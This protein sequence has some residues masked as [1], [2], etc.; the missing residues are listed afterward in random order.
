MSN[1]WS[2]LLFCIC[3][4]QHEL[5]TQK[6]ALLFGSFNILDGFSFLFL[7]VG[8]WFS[9][10]IPFFLSVVCVLLSISKRQI[11]RLN[12]TNKQINKRNVRK[13]KQN[14]LL[15]NKREISSSHF[16]A[17]IFVAN[18]SVAHNECNEFDTFFVVVIRTEREKKIER[19]SECVSV[20]FYHQMILWWMSLTW[21]NVNTRT[22]RERE[23]KRDER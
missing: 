19:E 22:Q 10:H 11:N 13:C 15:R 2:E 6:A 23:K 3:R 20:T 18:M 12:Q 7:F 17:F 16:Y 5:C 8:K 9:C 21:C 1:E 4:V 14:L